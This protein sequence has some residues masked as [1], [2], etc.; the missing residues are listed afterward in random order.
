MRCKK[1]IDGRSHSHNPWPTGSSVGI[2]PVDYAPAVLLKPFGPRLAADALPSRESSMWLQV[3]LSVSRLSPSCLNS[4]SI[5]SILSGP[6]GVT[7]A[8][9]Y[10]TRA[11]G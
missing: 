10:Q 5:P 3:G 7:P 8:F 4:L 2:A 9:G 1:T 6:R 11:T